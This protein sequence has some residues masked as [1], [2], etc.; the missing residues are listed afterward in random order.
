MRGLMRRAAV[1][2]ATAGLLAAGTVTVAARAA[3]A[4]TVSVIQAPLPANAGS[5]PGVSV[6]SVSCAS[7]GNCTAVG[8]AQAKISLMHHA[9]P[10][11]IRRA[12]TT[13]S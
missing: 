2:A 6:G 9:D 10:V 13:E 3:A 7:P 12:S 4:S 8:A 5:S 1:M 11:N